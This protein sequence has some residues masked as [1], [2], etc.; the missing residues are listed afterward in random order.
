[1]EVNSDLSPVILWSLIS[2]IVLRDLLESYL[3]LQS[4]YLVSQTCYY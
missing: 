2:V 4:L 3:L 1:V